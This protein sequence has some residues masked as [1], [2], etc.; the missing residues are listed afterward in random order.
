M[1]NTTEHPA[2]PHEEIPMKIIF[3]DNCNKTLNDF[4]C[5]DPI[6]INSH[7]YCDGCA[8]EVIAYGFKMRSVKEMTNDLKHEHDNE[9][10]YKAYDKINFGS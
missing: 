5:E 3:C 7:I 10:Y 2:W 6:K 9:M 8:S 1:N 4:E